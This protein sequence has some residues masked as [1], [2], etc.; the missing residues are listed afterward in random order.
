MI[1][2]ISSMMCVHDVNVEPKDRFKY[3]VPDCRSEMYLYQEVRF[4][5]LRVSEIL[6]DG[7]ERMEKLLLHQNRQR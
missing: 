3:Q 4:I 2:K 6:L 1:T 5:L 7:S